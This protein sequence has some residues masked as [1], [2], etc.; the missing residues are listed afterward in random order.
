[1]F[2]F[3]SQAN[4]NPSNIFFFAANYFSISDP[5]FLHFFLYQTSVSPLNDNRPVL[6]DTFTVTTI[7]TLKSKKVLRVKKKTPGI[8]DRARDE[9]K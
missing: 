8:S 3:F 7:I 6:L 2:T 4:L 9:T 5:N 1:V